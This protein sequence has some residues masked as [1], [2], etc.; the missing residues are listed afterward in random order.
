MNSRLGDTEH[1]NDLED[2]IIKITQSEHK[3]EKQILKNE[4]SLR[5][6]QD[7]IKRTNIHIIGALEEE[8]NKGV[9]NLLDD[10]VAEN[11]P[12]MKKTSGTGSTEGFKQ[13]E[14]KHTH[15]KTYHN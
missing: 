3:K 8:R 13:D 9:K 10:I 2:I 4:N 5:N 14:L 7:N 12:N 15:I 11:F 1:I 6:L